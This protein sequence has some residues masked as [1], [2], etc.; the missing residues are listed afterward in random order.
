VTHSP[1]IRHLV[2]VGFVAVSIAYT[3]AAGQ[4]AVVTNTIVNVRSGPGTSFEVVGRVKEGDR[5]PVVKVKRSWVQIK[6]DEETLKKIR[7]EDSEGKTEVWKGETWIF[8]KLIQFVGRLP[9]FHERQIEFQNWALD[10][11]P[12]T[13]I[14]FKSE[15]QI[16]VRLPP[17]Q[18]GSRAR[19][20]KIAR[21][22]AEEYKKQTGFMEREVVIKVLRGK[23]VYATVSH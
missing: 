9:D 4:E 11:I 17:D 1:A 10:A 15:W 21:K 12:V 5:F 16:W 19:V 6:I 13:F 2:L 14:E 18:Y 3:P 22:M 7:E 23:S 20:R 8:R